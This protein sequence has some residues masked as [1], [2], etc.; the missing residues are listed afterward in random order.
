MDNGGNDQ[1]RARRNYGK[2]SI[3]FVRRTGRHRLRIRQN[4]RDRSLYFD[5][6]EEAVAMQEAIVAAR[7][8]EEGVTLRQWGDIWLSMFDFGDAV[9]NTWKSLVCSAPFIDWPLHTI[10]SNDVAGWAESLLSKPATR[11]VL[12][13]GKRKLA[14]L[15]HAIARSYAKERPLSAAQLPRC[16]KEPQA[17]VDSDEPRGRRRATEGTERER[18]HPHEESEAHPQQTRL[19]TAGGLHEDLL[20]RALRARTRATS[21]RPRASR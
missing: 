19:P 7:D 15:D 14:T 17:A 18:P 8:C 13:N 20:L 5:S 10:T 12:R 9:P 6:V 16:G 1:S 11:S 21:R 3:T 2:G 4:G